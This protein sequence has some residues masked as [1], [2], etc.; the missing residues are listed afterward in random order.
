MTTGA[1]AAPKPIGNT[2]DVV[3]RYAGIGDVG[4]SVVG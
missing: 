2:K 4:F 1:A 3:A